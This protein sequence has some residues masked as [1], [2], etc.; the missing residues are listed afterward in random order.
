MGGLDAD[1]AAI[2]AKDR[3]LFDLPRLQAMNWTAPS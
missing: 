1:S 2:D 3:D